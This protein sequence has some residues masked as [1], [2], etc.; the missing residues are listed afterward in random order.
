MVERIKR[1]NRKFGSEEIQFQARIDV[2]RLP[3]NL[4]ATP[5]IAAIQCVR[6]LFS[7]ILSRVTVNISPNDLI[8]VCIRSDGLQKPISTN[9]M[10]ASEFSLDGRSN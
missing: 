9:L 6:Q 2:T 7:E 10:P 1:Q 8:R 3:A 4:K 5:L